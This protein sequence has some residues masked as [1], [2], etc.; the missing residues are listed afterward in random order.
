[1]L[2]TFDGII[3][4]FPGIGLDRFNIPASAFLLTHCHAD[5][6][7]GL[8]NKSF[9]GWIYCSEETKA[10]L[11]EDQRL[12]NVIPRVKALPYNVSTR[13]DVLDGPGD[14]F[15]VTLVEAYHCVGACMFLVELFATRS[16]AEYDQKPSKSVLCTG[17]LRAE[18]WWCELLVNSPL[19]APYLNG[20]RTL[21]NIYF[22]STFAYR[23]EPYIE[24][25]P[26][27]QGIDASIHLLKDY[28]LLDPKVRFEFADTTLGF[29][30]AWCT[31]VSYFRGLLVIPDRLFHAKIALVIDL[32]K[33]HKATL[34]TALVDGKEA[35]ER[36]KKRRRPQFYAGRVDSNVCAVR[37]KQCINFNILDYAGTSF[38]IPFESIPSDEHISLLYTT[39]KGTKF[40]RFRERNW[41]LPENGKELL[42]QEIKLVFSR[43]ST[44]SETH[45]FISK[46]KPRQVFPISF[47]AQAWRNGFTMKRLFQDICSDQK[48]LFDS[49]MIET[50]GLPP[51]EILDTKVSCINRWSVD[52]CERE[53]DMVL[54]CLEAYDKPKLKRLEDT[55]EKTLL[56]LRQVL[57]VPFDRNKRTD[58]DRE[59]LKRR[60]KDFALQK[61]VQGRGDIS[62]RNF[63]EEQQRLYYLQREFP[64]RSAKRAT[65]FHCKRYSPMLGGSSVYDTESDE[66]SMD[67]LNMGAKKHSISTVNSEQSLIQASPE[68]HNS[69]HA[70]YG[71]NART[72]SYFESSFGSFE[73]SVHP[74]KNTGECR[75]EVDSNQIL[76]MAELLAES[77]SLWLEFNLQSLKRRSG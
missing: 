64:W 34:K 37:I 72:K 48:F 24:S 66:S 69:N 56:K 7:V 52:E 18:R 54:N 6:L 12:K 55:S 25:P 68:I 8:A 19:L 22:D 1:M 62:Y 39:Q 49:M 70:V 16:D 44:Y 29:E 51:Q 26:N 65:F 58:D 17:D 15:Y 73:E 47:S 50:Y 27:N 14:A 36:Q 45:S 75:T 71:P 5:H 60:R 57:H 38:P 61:L 20:L 35:E 76:G 40:F 74:T 3:R 67:I 21:D 42:P 4:E 28:P 33:K 23:G 9:A 32:D 11:K 13:I 43:H 10:I 46:F 53:K 30:Q 31:I 41:I 77:P 63:I 59:Y 2:N